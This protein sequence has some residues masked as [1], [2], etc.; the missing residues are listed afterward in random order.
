[1]LEFANGRRA[2][3]ANLALHTSASRYSTHKMSERVRVTCRARPPTDRERQ[4]G[5]AL[6]STEGRTGIDLAPHAHSSNSARHWEFDS[7]HGASSTQQSVYDDV[8]APIL[9]AAMQGYNGTILAYGQTGAGK[10]HTLLNASGENSGLVP[11]LIASLYVAIGIDVRTVYTIRVSF[12]QIYNEQIDD[13]IKPRNSNLKLRPGGHEVEGLSLVECKSAEQ[14][15]QL[16]EAGRKNLVYAET[17]M[18]KTSSRSHAVLQIFIS[19][20]QRVLDASGVAAG[21]MQAT[22]LTG[23]LS[24]VDLAGSERVKR[25]G[26]DEDLS[27]RRMKEAINI[28]TSLLGLSNV[29]KALGSHAGYVPYRSM[30]KVAVLARR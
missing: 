20:R 7:V 1:M 27:G 16:L 6:T 26:A 5:L 12:A 30:V 15:L 21:S 11:R 28:N 19:R 8:G 13:L 3:H 17:K 29:M 22:Q 10:T 18:N 14:L 25:S 9:D 2:A 23:K 24:L 4:G